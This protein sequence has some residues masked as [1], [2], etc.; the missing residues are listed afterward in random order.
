M[1]DRETGPDRAVRLAPLDAL[2]GDAVERATLIIPAVGHLVDDLS[3][4]M[5]LIARY[6]GPVIK[7][8]LWKAWWDGSRESAVLSG[9]AWDQ[10]N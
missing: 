2:Y 9:E 5:D 4:F 3:P 8:G 1:R 6:N 7:F 10:S